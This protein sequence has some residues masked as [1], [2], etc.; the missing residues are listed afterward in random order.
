MS[1]DKKIIE[2]ICHDMASGN[3]N[4]Y[5]GENAFIIRPSG[6][7]LTEEQD[8]QMRSSN[9]I[10]IEKEEMV[11]INS[12]DI[13]GDVATVCFTV[14]Q[15]INYKGTEN[16]DNSVVLVVLKKENDTWKMVTGS[17]SQGRPPSEPL[18]IF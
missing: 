14:H 12:L 4:K 1:E 17:R 18:P 2:S 3:W 16:D 7:P 9:D 13:H 6:N 10:V 15:V 5:W 11:A 8:K